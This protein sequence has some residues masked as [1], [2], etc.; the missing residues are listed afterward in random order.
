MPEVRHAPV[1]VHDGTF[2]WTDDTHVS[3][4]LARAVLDVPAG[5][6]DVDAFGG[7]VGRRFVEWAQDPLTP[8]TAPGTTCLR[9]AR[10]F[11]R[12]GDWRRSGDPRSDGCGAV[13]RVVPLAIGFDEAQLPQAAR[14]SALLTHAHPNAVEAAIAGAWL[15][16]QALMHERFDAGMVATAMDHLRARWA[17]GGDVARSLEAAFEVARGPVDGWLEEDAIPPGDGG[18]RAGSA[19]GLDVAASL[20]FGAQGFVTVVDKAARIDGDSDSVAAL[21]GMLHGAAHGMDALPADWLRV[22][23]EREEIIAITDLLLARTAGSSAAPPT[24]NSRGPGQPG[25]I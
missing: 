5:P 14:V 4:Y 25:T 24:S 17:Q 9:G 1:I 15:C 21:A 6:L 7:A 22:L 23:P 20:R 2:R 19:L 18:W 8:S 3:L 12:S 10:A 16:R 11:M 13:M